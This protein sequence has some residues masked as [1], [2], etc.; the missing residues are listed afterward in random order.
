VAV[1]S[2]EEALKNLVDGVT[3]KGKKYDAKT[4]TMSTHFRSG[5]SRLGI[6]VGPVTGAAY[7]KGISGKGA[8]LERNAIAGARAKWIDNLKAG[9]SI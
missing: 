4:G 9:L 3:G 8:K 2:L 6:S 7:D 5:L 1:G